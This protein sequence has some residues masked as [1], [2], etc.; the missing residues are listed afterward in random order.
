MP[1]S[2][3]G[4]RRQHDGRAEAEILRD[5]D[6]YVGAER[7]ERAVRQIDHAADAEDQRQAKRDQQ[8][9]AS[10]HEAV[11]HLFQQEHELHSQIPLKAEAGGG[12]Q[13]GR[14]QRSAGRERRKRARVQLRHDLKVQGFCCLVGSMTSS[15]SFGCRH[16]GAEREEVPLVLGLALRP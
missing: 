2:A 7:V 16:G 3:D 11:D 10:E 15:G 13:F 8:V 12:R 5:L 9:V 14:R 6:R 1:S 4:D